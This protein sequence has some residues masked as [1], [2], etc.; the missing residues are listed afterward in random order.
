ML[1][2]N[3]YYWVY[4]T[5]RWEIAEWFVDHWECVGMDR[6]YQDGDFKK[7]GRMVAACLYSEK[8][9]A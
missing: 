6:G 5:E 7:I 2:A 4:H 3:G 9:K 8:E 1:R